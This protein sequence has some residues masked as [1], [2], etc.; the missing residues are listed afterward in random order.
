MTGVIVEATSATSAR[1]W[2]FPPSRKDWNGR[3]ESYLITATRLELQT[4]RERR[5]ASPPAVTTY[6]VSPQ[7]NHPDP[8]LAREPLQQET[9]EVEGLEEGFEYSFNISVVNAAGIGVSSE[10]EFQRM[11][12]TGN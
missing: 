11:N 4:S 5:A 2:W 3:I 7:A 10:S 9:G 8:S 12:E 1:L 6:S